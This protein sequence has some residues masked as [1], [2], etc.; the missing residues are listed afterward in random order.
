MQFG[1]LN[2]FIIIIKNCLFKYFGN[3]IES[4]NYLNQF[5]DI[6]S[7]FWGAVDP[8]K[9]KC[10]N[11]CLQSKIIYGKLINHVKEHN[12]PWLWDIISVLRITLT[13][14]FRYEN[15]P[16]HLICHWTFL[17]WLT[18]LL[19]F[20]SDVGQSVIIRS[21]LRAPRP[22]LYWYLNESQTWLVD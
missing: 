9:N 20:N 2:K 10:K 13:A 16:L 1:W 21:V 15:K 14:W 19:L 8:A 3:F 18:N 12:M 7:G 6:L 17:T 4:T 11:I 22:L 5:V